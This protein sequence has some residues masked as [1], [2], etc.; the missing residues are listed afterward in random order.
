MKQLAIIFYDDLVLFFPEKLRNQVLDDCENKKTIV[1]NC[2][3]Y[4]T[5]SIKRIINAPSTGLLDDLNESGK[6]EIRDRIDTHYQTKKCFPSDEEVKKWV[7]IKKSRQ[8]N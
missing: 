2:Q 5:A 4:Q 3:L 8:F 1:L 6:K 7:E